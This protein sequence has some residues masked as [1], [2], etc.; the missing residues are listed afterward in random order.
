L[1]FLCLGSD[2]IFCLII[3][4]FSEHFFPAERYGWVCMLFPLL[5]REM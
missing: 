1:V 4:L 5:S 3:K 2:Y